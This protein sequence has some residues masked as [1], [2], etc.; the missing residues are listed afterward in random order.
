MI[1]Q[2]ET[3]R[4]LAGQLE[5]TVKHGIS[6]DSEDEREMNETVVN[7]FHKA[8]PR[9]HSSKGI[10]D[11]LNK[12]NLTNTRIENNKK[13]LPSKYNSMHKLLYSRK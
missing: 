8:I 9:N 3:I 4:N 6:A 5:T 13:K 7:L 2:T 11:L 12:P 1:A 10:R